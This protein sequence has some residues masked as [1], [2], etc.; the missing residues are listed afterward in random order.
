MLLPVMPL[1][2]TVMCKHLTFTG[3][4]ATTVMYNSLLSKRPQQQL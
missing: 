3:A 2:E 4:P 1:I